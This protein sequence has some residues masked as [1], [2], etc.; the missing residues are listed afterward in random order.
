[1]W[2]DTGFSENGEDI[3]K[4]PDFF[5]KTPLVEGE[6]ILAVQDKG[7][8]TLPVHSPTWKDIASFFTYAHDG[9]HGFLEGLEWEADTR[10]ITMLTG[11]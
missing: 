8:P 11:S 6:V 3:V 5:D 9:H 2:E 7:C 10:T 1:M 4:Y